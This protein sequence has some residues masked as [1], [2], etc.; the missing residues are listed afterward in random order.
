MAVLSTQ[1]VGHEFCRD[2]A[3]SAELYTR[4]VAHHSLDALTR[5]DF[6]KAVYLGLNP[7]HA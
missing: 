5:C 1:G 3:G 4:L 6:D 2:R 7:P